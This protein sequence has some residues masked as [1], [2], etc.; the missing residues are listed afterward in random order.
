MAK[1]AFDILIKYAVFKTTHDGTQSISQNVHLCSYQILCQSIDYLH[2]SSPSQVLLAALSSTCLALHSLPK[3]MR[4]GYIPRMETLGFEY[5]GESRLREIVHKFH[6]FAQKR[7][8]RKTP[9]LV[10]ESDGGITVSLPRPDVRPNETSFVCIFERKEAIPLGEHQETLCYRCRP[11]NY[12]TKD[13]DHF[14][15]RN[16]TVFSAYGVVLIESIHLEA[17][18]PQR[19]DICLFVQELTSEVSD[20]DALSVIVEDLL[21]SGNIYHTIR[22]PIPPRYARSY[23][24]YARYLMEPSP[25]TPAADREAGAGHFR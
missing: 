23:P 14:T 15:P 3:R 10:R 5:L 4:A 17:V 16:D 1:A 6:K 7:P 25:S 12:H 24:V 2:S 20:N 22:Y 13:Q 11:G 9:R 8:V 18:R 19:H 21:Q